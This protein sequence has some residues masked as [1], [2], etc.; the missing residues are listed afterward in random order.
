MYI[1]EMLRYVFKRQESQAINGNERQGAK[2]GRTWQA[3]KRE[4]QEI[5]DE[6]YL[7]ART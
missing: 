5:I 4:F 2:R 1:R 6:R 7:Y 3:P